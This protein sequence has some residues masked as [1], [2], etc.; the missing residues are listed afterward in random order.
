MAIRFGD[1]IEIPI[2]QGLAYAQYTHRVKPYGALIRVFETTRRQ[3]PRDWAAMA[4][5]PIAFSVF[6]PLNSAVRQKVVQVV[7]RTEVAAW[8]R[9]LP[10]FRDGNPHPVTRKVDTW[11]LW[12]GEREWEVGTLTPEQRRMPILGVWDVVMLVARIEE[13]W[14][15]ELDPR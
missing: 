10:V 11:W 9:A 7:G 15:P 8:N 2:R 6:F 5:S 3:R 1:I 14:R 4:V 12:D 13:G